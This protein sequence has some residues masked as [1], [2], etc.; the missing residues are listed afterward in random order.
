[1]PST[2]NL[3]RTTNLWNQEDINLYNKL[4]FYLANLEAKYY[5]IWHVWDKFFGTMKWEQNMGTV[6]KGVRAEPTPIG[7]ATFFPNPITSAPNKDVMEVRELSEQAIVY[8]HLYESP[9]FNFNPSF[10]DFRKNQIGF[11]MKDLT[12]QIAC[13]N[14]I[15]I[16]TYVLQ[17][18]PA[19]FISGKPITNNGDGF[20]GAE[21]VNAPTGVGDINGLTVK[22][23]AW[24]QQAAAY[25]GSNLGNLGYKVIKKVCQVLKQDI[26]A[27]YFEGQGNMPA[28]N[29]TMKGKYVLIGG[30]EALE[31]LSF[32]P[33][34]LANRELSLD[35][36]TKEFDGSIGS[37]LVWK[38]ER[39]PLRMGA[40]GS[41]PYPQTFE[42][43][44]A[45]YNV[46]MTVP[47]PAYV[48]APLEWAFLVAADAFR[49]ITIGAP[50]KE[51]A[52][53]TMS[54][55]RASI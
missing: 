36:L 45:A 53:G 21:L 41:F 3:P 19:V 47:N 48:T 38:S 51:F 26:Q 28:D 49:S 16:R 40:D 35:I 20:D 22:S 42:A 7:R 50:P 52:G 30:D 11:A 29:E 33:F 4:P 12:N 17:Y 44:P 43:N 25:V 55:R 32:D 15:F 24:L 6:M 27:P 2:Y 1:M 8:R 39:F 14:N 5:P 10:Q 46:G 54:G 18:A 9:Y 23:T 37:H 31:F 13:A 34:I